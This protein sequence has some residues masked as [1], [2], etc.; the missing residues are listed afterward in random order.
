MVQLPTELLQLSQEISREE[1]AHMLEKLPNSKAAGLNGLPYE[2][3]ESL[4][5]EHE[6]NKEFNDPLC[7][8]AQVLTI[9]FNN[10][11]K[12]S[13]VPGT[14]FS[15]GWLCPLYKKKDKRDI[16]NYQPITLLN[17][18]YKIFT[19]ALALR[20][21]DDTAPS[22]IHVDQAGVILGQSIFDQF[23][24]TEMMIDF[25]EEEL[26]EGVIV[27]LDQENAYD[28]VCHD[29]IW[30]TLTHMGFPKHIVDTVKGL[31]SDAYTVVI[32]NR[33]ISTPYKVT[34]GVR[35]GDPLS[36]LL[37]N[38]AIE[39]MAEMICTSSLKGIT[40][41]GLEYRIIVTLFANDTTV[42]LSA[43]DNFKDLEDILDS[44]CT[45]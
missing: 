42:Y 9:V 23:H 31:Y 30:T 3:W 10:I 19:K 22:V 35:Q 5:E 24:L 11:K 32:I 27:A 16:A 39:P 33:E 13:V 26:V 6:Q 14:R 12:N 34:R 41:P 18:D 25:T 2:I 40:V 7:N 29:Y 17:S 45:A 20:L 44:W 1:V 28:K 15:D 8:I 38:L 4:H 43:K 21:A 36:C 37:F